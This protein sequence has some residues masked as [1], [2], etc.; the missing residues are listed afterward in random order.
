MIK[1]LLREPLLHFLLLGAV[2]FAAHGMLSRSGAGEPGSI[3]VTQGQI[4]SMA[5]LFTRARQRAPSDAEL[6]EIIRGHVREE[7]FYREGLALGLDRNDPEIRRRVAQK[8]NSSPKPPKRSSLTIRNCRPI[9]I[10]TANCM[11]SNRDTASATSI[12]TRADASR[13]LRSTWNECSAN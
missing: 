2:L 10:R 1:R 12:S 7:V 4:E 11:R 13:H 8:R 3:V 6:E 9:S 5:R